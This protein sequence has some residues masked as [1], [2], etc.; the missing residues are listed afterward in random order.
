MMKIKKHEWRKWKQKGIISVS[1]V[2]HTLVRCK[3]TSTRRKTWTYRFP[4]DH[5]RFSNTIGRDGF[6]VGTKTRLL[7]Q[8]EIW[9][10]IGY[11]Q[12]HS[13]VADWRRDGRR[14]RC[15]RCDMR[16]DAGRWGSWQDSIAGSH[17]FVEPH[18]K[19]TQVIRWGDSVL[20]CPADWSI[21]WLLEMMQSQ[22]R[23]YLI[24]WLINCDVVSL[25]LHR[26][27]LFW[28]SRSVQI[29][30]ACMITKLF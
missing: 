25:I 4:A 29:M 8:S 1:T 2:D 27:L 28:P 20:V 3:R 23:P 6:Q 22:H 10:H 16:R 24:D 11:A 12:V 21:D 9:M 14:D 5:T 30:S 26:H 7:G 15:L 19:T 18:W 17:A 13:D